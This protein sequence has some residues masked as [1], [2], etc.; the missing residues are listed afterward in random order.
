[1][2]GEGKHTIPTKT[3]QTGFGKLITVQRLTKA[4]ILFRLQHEQDH[5]QLW[6]T[7]EPVMAL[8][9]CWSSCPSGG[10][11]WG[12][13]VQDFFTYHSPFLHQLPFYTWSTCT[14]SDPQE[15]G[16]TTWCANADTACLQIEDGRRGQRDWYLQ[17][18]RPLRHVTKS[19]IEDP[20]QKGAS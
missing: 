1:M 5:G 16:H 14:F 18:P 15:L 8:K 9:L 12:V 4:L 10:M 20:R 2:P 17:L 6:P 13:L 11:L 7:Q 19:S 3:S